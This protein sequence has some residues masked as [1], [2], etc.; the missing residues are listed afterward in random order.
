MLFFGQK[1][2][3]LLSLIV[4]VLG[5]GWGFR[6][7]GGNWGKYSVCKALL[8]TVISLLKFKSSEIYVVMLKK[9][10]FIPFQVYSGKMSPV[11]EHF[12][13]SRNERFS[14]PQTMM[15]SGIRQFGQS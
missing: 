2:S 13:A 3:I 9:T 14:S 5:I 12:R 6:K 8:G 11:I 1:L 10:V 4:G 7:S 15:G